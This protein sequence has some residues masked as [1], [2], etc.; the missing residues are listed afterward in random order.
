MLLE[1]IEEFRQMN[2]IEDKAIEGELAKLESLLTKGTNFAT[3]KDAVEELKTSLTSIID[4]AKG[5]TDVASVSGQYFRKLT[6]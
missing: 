4:E 5:V 2:F 6:I 3:N 1:N